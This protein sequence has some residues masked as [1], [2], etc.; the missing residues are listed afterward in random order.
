MIMRVKPITYTTN[1]KRVIILS[2]EVSFYE[3]KMNTYL[4]KSEQNVNLW[5]FV[6]MTRVS[7]GLGG[8]PNF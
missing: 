6:T 7:V 2:Q 4:T 3:S 1:Q 5:T 8:L